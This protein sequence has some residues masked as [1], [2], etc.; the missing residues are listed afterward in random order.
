MSPATA[1]ALQL[2]TAP[3]ASAGRFNAHLLNVTFEASSGERRS[4][5]GGGESVPDAIAAARDELPAGTW[6]LARWKPLYGE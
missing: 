5:V 4:A 3:E 6:T 1:L 2:P